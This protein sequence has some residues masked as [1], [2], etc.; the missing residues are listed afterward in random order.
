MD[1]HT[2]Q[3]QSLIKTWQQT[4]PSIGWDLVAAGLGSLAFLLFLFV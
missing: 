2:K 1:N 4:E 3:R